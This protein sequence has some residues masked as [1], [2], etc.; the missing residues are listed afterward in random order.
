MPALGA[1][2]ATSGAVGVAS[3]LTS[4]PSGLPVRPDLAGLFPFGVLRR[5]GTV[6][7]RGS[8]SLLLSLLAEPTAQDSWAAVVGLPDLGVVAA[9]ELGVAVDR[10]ALVRDPGASVAS[11]VAALLDGMDLVVVARGRL[12]DAQARRLSARARHRGA[13][14]LTPD[15]WPGVD[16]ELRCVGSEWA[17]VGAGEGYLAGREVDVRS[18][19]RG[20]AARGGRVVVRVPGGR[21]PVARARAPGRF[22]V[23]SRHQRFP[24]GVMARRLALTPLE[25]ERKFETWMAPRSACL[26][27]GVPT[28]R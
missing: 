1:S 23:G 6:S 4:T 13:V 10:V 25:I 28:G 22:V 20:V 21:G 19:G 24:R 14:L 8:T 15:E 11:V 9:A 26:S 18:R 12:P 16:V 5:G 17:G 2:L 27:C 3:D 7:V